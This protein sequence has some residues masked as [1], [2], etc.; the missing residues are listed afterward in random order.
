MAFPKKATS[1]AKSGLNDGNF[2][3]DE[4]DFQEYVLHMVY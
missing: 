1:D 2:G 4:G 3:S